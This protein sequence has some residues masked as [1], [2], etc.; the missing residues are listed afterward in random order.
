MVLL[1]LKT[2]KVHCVFPDGMPETTT[3]IVEFTG[4][5]ST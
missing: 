3:L 5:V 1:T 4:P 2:I